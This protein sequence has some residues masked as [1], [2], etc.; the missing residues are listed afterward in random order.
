MFTFVME[1]ELL[2]YFRHAYHKHEGQT[3]I[4]QWY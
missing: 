3:L 2:I 1:Y 4:N